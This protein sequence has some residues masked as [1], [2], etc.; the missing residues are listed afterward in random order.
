MFSEG[1]SVAWKYPRD[2]E[3]ICFVDGR[4]DP[5]WWRVKHKGVIY[6]ARESELRALDERDLPQFEREYRG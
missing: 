1:Q 2:K 6:Q 5:G 4:G 3:V